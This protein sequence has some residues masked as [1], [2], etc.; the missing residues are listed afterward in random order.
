VLGMDP[1]FHRGD[2]NIETPEEK[3]DR[4]DSFR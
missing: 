4:A 3:L 2:D 1:G